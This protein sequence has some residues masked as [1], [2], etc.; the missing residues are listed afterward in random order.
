MIGIGLTFP[1]V[2]LAG[3]EPMAL[4]IGA[5]GAFRLTADGVSVTAQGEELQIESVAL[6]AEGAGAEAAAPAELALGYDAAGGA[7]ELVLQEDAWSLHRQGGDTPLKLPFWLKPSTR[8]KV[9]G[10]SPGHV[11]LGG[12]DLL[13]VVD[14][15]AGTVTAARLGRPRQTPIPLVV[16]ELADLLVG[17]DVLRCSGP[18]RCELVGRLPGP[19]SAAVVGDQA[20][21]MA[22]GGREPGL[23]RAPADR[24]LSGSRIYGGEVVA[25][26]GGRESPAWALVRRD[27]ESVVVAVSPDTPAL[28]L[29]S[30]SEL[31]T[32]AFLETALVDAE[33]GVQLLVRARSQRW[34]GL[35]E[36]A[37]QA[38]RDRRPAMR[39]AAAVALAGESSSRA[40]AGL[41]LAS[42][43]ADPEVRLAAMEASR[44]RCAETR[45]AGCR[46]TLVWFVGDSDTEVSYGARDGLLLEDPALALDG[47][48]LAYR[49]EA[50]GLLVS[51]A[52]RHGFAIA[53]RGLELLSQ[54]P[55]NAV[56][57]AARR[58]LESVTP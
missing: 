21:V 38:L 44:A 34:P 52:E 29:L 57:E 28:R 58:A 55:D 3:G 6:Q 23:Y 26:C 24:P 5:D 37:L 13:A 35:L 48:P 32:V 19:V 49:R 17:G 43:D 16:G 12:V 15:E 1:L 51:R 9:L 47:A 53:R 18:G 11:W 46:R 41:W 10:Q 14:A 7:Y 36:L 42:R 30:T 56:R 25:L 40:L 8:L 22:V 39:A 33:I 4:C 50:V 31:M 27:G 45:Q 54:D 2:L 20:V